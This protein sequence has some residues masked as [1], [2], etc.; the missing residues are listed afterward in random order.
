MKDFLKTILCGM[1]IICLSASAVICFI[2]GYLAFK[3]S[4]NAIGIWAIV[5]FIGSILAFIGG[6]TFVWLIGVIAEERNEVK[7]NE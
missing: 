5:S 2:L 6:V 4:L 3:F 7:N 1:E